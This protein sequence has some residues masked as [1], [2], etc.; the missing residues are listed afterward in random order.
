MGKG[1]YVRRKKR[2]GGGDRAPRTRG[3]EKSLSA[4]IYREKKRR[5]EC[6]RE[7]R[8]LNDIRRREVLLIL[9]G[10]G[11]PNANFKLSHAG[12]RRRT[13][14]CSN[15]EVS[16]GQVSVTEEGRERKGEK[17]I[18]EI[19]VG[20]EKRRRRPPTSLHETWKEKRSR[21]K[22]KSPRQSTHEEKGEGASL[23]SKLRGEKEKD[24]NI[25]LIVT[26]LRRKACLSAR[27]SSKKTERVYSQGEKQAA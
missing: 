8:V 21:P 4:L 17:L 14:V 24:R 3:G 10:K 23:F 26:T 6:E 25:E 16:T 7:R 22:R 27:N 2:G 11:N 20:K 12:S 19:F 9:W 18:S 13:G 1:T 15:R 5:E